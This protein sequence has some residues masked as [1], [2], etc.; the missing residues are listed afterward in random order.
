M[1]YEYGE[2]WEQSLQYA[3]EITKADGTFITWPGDVSKRHRVIACINACAG[4]SNEDL[5]IMGLGGVAQM[6]A[7]RDQLKAHHEL[8]N[9]VISHLQNLLNERK[10]GSSGPTLTADQATNWEWTGEQ[11]R[12]LRRG[13]SGLCEPR[14]DSE[15]PWIMRGCPT[16][17]STSFYWPLRRRP[18]PKAD[19]SPNPQPATLNDIAGLLQRILDR[20]PEREAE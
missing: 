17:E 9:R 18:R 19:E 5:E 11:P 20:M 10:T 7:H 12:K 3:C 1:T 4:I 8:D 2:P 16:S 13:E 15:R 14:H 6:L